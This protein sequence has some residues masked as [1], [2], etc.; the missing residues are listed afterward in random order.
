[1][2]GKLLNNHTLFTIKSLES[3]LKRKFNKVLGINIIKS[4]KSNKLTAIAK[5]SIHDMVWFLDLKLKKNETI[6]DQ[7]EEFISHKLFYDYVFSTTSEPCI[8]SVKSQIINALKFYSGR[9]VKRFSEDIFKALAY[10]VFFSCENF[11]EAHKYIVDKFEGNNE[12]LP[13]LEDNC[14][15]DIKTSIVAC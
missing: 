1:M 5:L 12:W 15:I 10:E 13:L 14:K 6:L 2:D 4:K 7:C 11:I 3:E 8:N 9:D